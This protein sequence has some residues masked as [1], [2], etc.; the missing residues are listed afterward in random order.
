[1]NQGL[2]YWYV[3]LVTIYKKN[4][5]NKRKRIHNEKKKEIALQIQHTTQNVQN[6]ENQSYSPWIERPRDSETV[7]F[8]FGKLLFKFSQ[9]PG[10]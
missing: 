7:P 10:T 1:M 6:K 8:Q 9:R 4:T 5:K 3:P 2:S